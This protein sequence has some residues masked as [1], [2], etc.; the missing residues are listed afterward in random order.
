MSDY[1]IKTPEAFVSHFS[2]EV[3]NFP[4]FQD[5]LIDAV[6]EEIKA[7]TRTVISHE[8]DSIDWRA[9]CAAIGADPAL[10][11][12]KTREILESMVEKVV[13]DKIH[14]DKLLKNNELILFP[15]PAKLPELP[16]L[17]ETR[18]EPKKDWVLLLD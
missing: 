15:E 6:R 14:F 8:F 10:G 3:I 2:Q 4:L 12:K 1:D 9:I 17:A 16:K 5:N 11:A 7:M 18:S 13:I